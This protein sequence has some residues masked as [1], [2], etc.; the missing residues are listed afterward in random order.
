M[1]L[2]TTVTK[3]AK[4]PGPPHTRPTACTACANTHPTVH[5]SAV[6]WQEEGSREGS[7]AELAQRMAKGMRK[8]R[9]E[10]P[11]ERERRGERG[12]RE[13]LVRGGRRRVRGGREKRR[14]EGGREREGEGGGREREGREK[15]GEGEGEKKRQEE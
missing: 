9:R 12:R 4:R 3:T 2:E 5:A 13:R 7:G 8:W 15:G 14:E 10:M 11:C 1:P 6:T